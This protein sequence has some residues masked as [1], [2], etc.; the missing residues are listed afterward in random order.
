MKL[1]N[2]H[3]EACPFCGSGKGIVSI[4]SSKPAY[5][6]HQRAYFV[7]CAACGGRSGERKSP[8]EA[9]SAWNHRKEDRYA[10]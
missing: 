9:A 5:A 2:I 4:S 7:K 10:V 8:E 6:N 3:L 1:E